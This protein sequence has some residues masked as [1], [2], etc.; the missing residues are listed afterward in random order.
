M[1]KK[2]GLLLNHRKLLNM[3]SVSANSLYELVNIK[4]YNETDD[5]EFISIWRNLEN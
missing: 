3:T 4:I 1:L 2:A 5:L